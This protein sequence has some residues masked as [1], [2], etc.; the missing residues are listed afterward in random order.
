[1][2]HDKPYNYYLNISCCQTIPVIPYI[3]VSK[4]S[5]HK[6]YV[7]NNFGWNDTEIPNV[8]INWEIV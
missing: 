3:A 4:V 1:M 2:I 5:K 8:N 6:K 7:W